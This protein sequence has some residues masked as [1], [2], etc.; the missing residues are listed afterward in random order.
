MSERVS[1]ATGSSK[2]QKF[3]DLRRLLR[4]PIQ[5]CLCMHASPCTR[6]ALC[7]NTQRRGSGSDGDGCHAVLHLFLKAACRSLRATPASSLPGT[8]CQRGRRRYTAACRPRCCR[9][10]GLLLPVAAPLTRRLPACGTHAWA[11]EV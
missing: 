7:I 5:Q 3:D 2:K 1:A 10:H 11:E 6:S 4:V 8:A 9:R